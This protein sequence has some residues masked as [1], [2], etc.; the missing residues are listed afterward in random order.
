MIISLHMNIFYGDR[1][2]ACIWDDFNTL[3]S[4]II[5]I[6]GSEHGSDSRHS[7]C[8]RRCTRYTHQSKVELTNT[9]LRVINDKWLRGWG[10]GWGREWGCGEEYHVGSTFVGAGGNIDWRR[11]GWG[12]GWNGR[13]GSRGGWIWEWKYITWLWRRDCC[14]CCC[15]CCR[16]YKW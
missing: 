5:I 3:R 12:R 6:K 4:Q 16:W 13:R 14:C 10:G 1:S 8:E 7:T 15:R 11:R 2:I 9:V